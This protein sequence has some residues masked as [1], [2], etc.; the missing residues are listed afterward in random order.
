M[1]TARGGRHRRYKQTCLFI[2]NLETLLLARKL[3]RR[4]RRRR[5]ASLSSDDA[6]AGDDDGDEEGNLDDVDAADDDDDGVWPGEFMA[7]VPTIVVTEL[8]PEPERVSSRITP[9]EVER[10]IGA[11]FAIGSPI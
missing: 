9:E 4:R 2:G 6:A 1:I 5:S 10:A 8:E 11:A 3:R 7:A